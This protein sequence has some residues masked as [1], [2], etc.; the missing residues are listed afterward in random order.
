MMDRRKGLTGLILAGLLLIPGSLG[1]GA[2]A[3]AQNGSGKLTEEQRRQMEQK[4]QEEWKTQEQIQKFQEDTGARLQSAE[5]HRRDA[6]K[7]QREAE[8]R[9][10]ERRQQQEK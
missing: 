3:L 6:E 8:R 1:F 4:Y 9:L 5:K 10:R 7:R 2:S